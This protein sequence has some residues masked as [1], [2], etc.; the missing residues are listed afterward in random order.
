L[1]VFLQSAFLLFLPYFYP[2]S[3]DFSI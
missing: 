2:F 1:A 3:V